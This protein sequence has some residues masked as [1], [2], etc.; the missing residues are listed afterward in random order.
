MPATPRAFQF[1]IRSVHDAVTRT[2][3]TTKAGARE[4]NFPPWPRRA[5]GMGRGG[6]SFLEG[7]VDDQVGGSG[8]RGEVSLADDRHRIGSHVLDRLRRNDRLE[9][10]SAHKAGFQLFPVERH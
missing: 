6:S 3:N 10:A 2:K 8:P 1:M 4:S 9:L 7:N 5:V